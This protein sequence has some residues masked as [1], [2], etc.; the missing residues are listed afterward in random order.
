[1]A[2]TKDDTLEPSAELPAAALEKP[3]A[4]RRLGRP[5]NP[6]TLAEALGA[7]MVALAKVLGAGEPETKAPKPDPK[8]DA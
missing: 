6:R 5:R 8:G 2:R 7:R 4:K 1:M 3:P